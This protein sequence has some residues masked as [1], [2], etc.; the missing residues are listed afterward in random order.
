MSSVSEG[1]SVRMNSSHMPAV[2]G[3]VGV[4]CLGAGAW[5]LGVIDACSSSGILDKIQG[6]AGQ[7]FQ[8]LAS[9]PHVSF[10]LVGLC[11]FVAGLTFVFVLSSVYQTIKASVLGTAS[12][13]YKQVG[14]TLSH[15]GMCMAASST[16]IVFWLKVASANA[17]AAL[18]GLIAHVGMA[19]GLAAFLY[20]AYQGYST[21]SQ[22]K[23]MISQLE[24]LQKCNSGEELKT[25]I[26]NLINEGKS[27]DKTQLSSVFSSSFCKQLDQISDGDLDKELKAKVIL[28]FIHEL[29]VAPKLKEQEDYL[30]A[31]FKE[32]EEERKVLGCFT[33]KK[34][35][36]ERYLAI[37]RA[38]KMKET[39]G[40]VGSEA[41]K[42]ASQDLS[43]PAK[44]PTARIK[45]IEAV[46]TL[47][48]A[49]EDHK[50]SNYIDIACSI[51]GIAAFVFGFTL[52]PLG[53]GLVATTAV[54]YG[55]W[56]LLLLCWI[57]KGLKESSENQTYETRGQVELAALN[58]DYS[59]SRALYKDTYLIVAN[60]TWQ[61]EKENSWIPDFIYNFWNTQPTLPTAEMMQTIHEVV[62]EMF[63]SRGGVEMFDK[64]AIET[65][66][67]NP[68]GLE[69]FRHELFEKLNEK[70][71]VNKQCPIE[72]DDNI[73]LK[74]DDNT[75]HQEKMSEKQISL[76][77][78]RAILK[79][80]Y[81]LAS[82]DNVIKYDEEEDD[83][84]IWKASREFLEI[85]E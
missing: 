18:C 39:F 22:T 55:C 57:A 78:C 34:E 74:T 23:A 68:L 71:E 43:E 13:V 15:L 46:G 58:N 82:N 85:S 75:Q 4:G 27:D 36:V 37:A 28:G 59:K 84:H 26:L 65:I 53:A 10:P 8:N 77:F 45:T 48:A 44:T 24:S 25:T 11:S 21:L 72:V 1:Q 17:N 64:K 16:C 30:K 29:Y 69:G 14:E 73:Q 19:A 38:Q 31:T 49:L 33:L 62:E 83:G 7:F 61:R 40:F 41:L 12:D 20:K 52:P 42:I 2:Y 50:K 9:Q 79:V 80:R 81:A 66:L 63:V 47:R 3:A 51:L 54:I 60:V 76:D 67:L 6:K 32:G 56:S 5:T 70:L 35:T